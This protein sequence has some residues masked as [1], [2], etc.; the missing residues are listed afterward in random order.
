MKVARIKI[1]G[2][3][4]PLCFSTRVMC[5]AAEKFG[6][7]DK[8]FAVMK[9]DDLSRKLD[10]IFWLLAELL[11]AGHAYAALTGEDC[12]EPLSAEQL[13]DLYGMDDLAGLTTVVAEAVTAGAR[14][15]VEAEPP[16][17][18]GAARED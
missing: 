5:N 2:Q 7:M 9:N 15:T 4:R 11:R 10:G 12:P 1:L 14:R 8:L 6:G 17:N 13:Q 16:K 3:E 18:S